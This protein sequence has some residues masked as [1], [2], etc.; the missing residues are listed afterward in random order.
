MIRKLFVVALVLLP[1][2]FLLDAVAFG[3]DV[4]TKKQL[5]VV[6][7]K[8][9]LARSNGHYKHAV[10]LYED[11]TVGFVRREKN[12]VARLDTLR[13]HRDALITYGMQLKA[14]VDMLEARDASDDS[15]V[16]WLIGA[17]IGALLIG[18]GVGFVIG[19]SYR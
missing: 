3:E 15:L 16:K 6:F 11:L 14:T 9:E 19:K 18:G 7:A 8:A 1:V 17:C 10:D 13:D 2:V 4:P 12:L 5:A